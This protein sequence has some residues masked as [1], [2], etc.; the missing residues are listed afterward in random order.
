MHI[1]SIPNHSGAK[2]I[3]YWYIIKEKSLDYNVVMHILFLALPP[4]QK[5]PFQILPS[6]QNWKVF[7]LWLLY[8]KEDQSN[9]PFFLIQFQL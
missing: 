5:S 8:T 9:V 1:S 7:T 3:K 4:L 2:M 6:D